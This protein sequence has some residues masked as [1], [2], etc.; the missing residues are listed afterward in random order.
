MGFN[1]AFNQLIV[2]PGLIFQVRILDK[3]KLAMRV[4]YS[5][6]NSLSLSKILAM[7]K[8]FNPAQKL[9]CNT[10]AFI[11]A[12]IINKNNLFPGILNLNSSNLAQQA[13]KRLLFIIAGD[14][15]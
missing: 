11:T 14:N 15:Y 10:V 6:L 5:S 12:V 7:F 13:R 9:F 2:I 8:N 1:R 3:D 4:F